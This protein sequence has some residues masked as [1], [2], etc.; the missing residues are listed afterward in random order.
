MQRVL[1][2]Q[3]QRGCVRTGVE[4]ILLVH[5]LRRRGKFALERQAAVGNPRGQVLV[6]VRDEAVGPFDLAPRR[7]QPGRLAR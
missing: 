2:D 6:T 7:E 1:F 3:G 5:L 4:E